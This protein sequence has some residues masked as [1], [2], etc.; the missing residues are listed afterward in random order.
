MLSSENIK[1]STF[2]LKSIL[3]ATILTFTIVPIFLL[4]STENIQWTLLSVT[5]W[6]LGSLLIFHP[7]VLYVY[8]HLMSRIGFYLLTTM[9]I[10]VSAWFNIT[11]ITLLLPNDYIYF[12]LFNSTLNQISLVGSSYVILTNAIITSFV[13]PSSVLFYKEERLF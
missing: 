2:F 9:L 8:P 1:S 3:I 6:S 13:F 11:M 7:F 10:I 5:I 4:L 12:A